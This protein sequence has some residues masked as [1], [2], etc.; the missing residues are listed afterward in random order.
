MCR[1]FDGLRDRG[2]PRSEVRIL[3]RQELASSINETLPPECLRIVPGGQ[4][5]IIEALAPETRDGVIGKAPPWR[6][7]TLARVADPG[8]R[9]GR[10][11][12][13]PRPLSQ[14]AAALGRARM[15]RTGNGELCRYRRREGSAR[16]AFAAE[17]GKL[18][19]RAQ[20]GSLGRAGRASA[21]A[22]AGAA[23]ARHGAEN[24]ALLTL[25]WTM[26]CV[27]NTLHP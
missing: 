24:I 5:E 10:L 2:V 17:R 7:P 19:R 1:G 4:G 9:R 18:C 12:F 27:T 25:G 20:G 14:P 11:R 26:R 23:G 8:L 21:G 16:R 13:S 3:D 6:E 22:G 15:R